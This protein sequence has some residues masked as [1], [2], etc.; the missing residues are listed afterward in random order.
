VRTLI[1][2]GIKSGKSR[3]ALL[4]AEAFDRPRY[5][6]ATAEAFDG[7]MAERI[8]KHKI[9]RAERFITME[10]PVNIIEHLRENL[11]LDCI[12][13]WI[14]N[15][16]HYGMH[17]EMDALTQQL[18]EALPRSIVIVTNEIGMG[19]VPADPLSRQYGDV[20]GRMNGMLAQACDQVI[21]MVAGLPLFVKSPK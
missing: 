6:L 12:P 2:G 11:V 10:E 5:F 7:E 4:L 14:N 1:T 8:S 15:L 16:F 17:K 13:L 21:L 18:I 20:L 19:F 9:E 3:Q